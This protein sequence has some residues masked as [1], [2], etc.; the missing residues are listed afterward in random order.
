M[1]NKFTY[2]DFL[3]YIIPGGMFAIVLYFFF[4]TLPTVKPIIES[5]ANL[6]GLA[7]FIIISFVFGN[8]IQALA[9]K[10]LEDFIKRWYWNGFYASDLIF[11]ENNRIINDGLRLKMI[12]RVLSKG[13]TTKE[14]LQPII[15][16]GILKDKKLGVTAA[17]IF[18]CLRTTAEKD[19]NSNQIKGAE[20]YYQFFRGLTAAFFLSAIFLF[21]FYVLVMLITAVGCILTSDLGWQQFA[22][23]AGSNL[24]WYGL[25][26]IICF[27]IGIVFMDRARGAGQGYIRLI[28]RL[29]CFPIEE[30]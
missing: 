17:F 12:D 28:V 8:L 18:N 7:I 2:F 9:H 26:G 10:S 5:T 25:A 21:G 23:I 1:E 4:I 3:M 13:W 11:N 14:K 22:N 19:D 27:V 30:K 6:F 16:G 24:V 15:D 20:A 29:F